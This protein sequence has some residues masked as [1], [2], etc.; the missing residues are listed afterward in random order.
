MSELPIHQLIKQIKLVEQFWDFDA[1]S[2]Y[3]S[4]MSDENSIYT[5][6]ETGY[7]FTG[8]T[9]DELVEKF[10][11]QT[12]N[13]GSAFLIIKYYNSS[14]LIVQYLPVKEKVK[15]LKLT[16]RILVLL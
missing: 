10:N 9:N 15:K 16:V 12:F 6:I 14:N 5:G 13:H 8:D 11:T 7:V 4:A 1:V 3:P 2:F